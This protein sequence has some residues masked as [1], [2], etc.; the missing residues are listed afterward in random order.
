MRYQ[1]GT[2][3]RQLELEYLERSSAPTGGPTAGSAATVGQQTCAICQTRHVMVESR[4]S[5]RTDLFHTLCFR[6]YH[7]QMQRKRMSTRRRAQAAVR[8]AT[9]DLIDT[10]DTVRQR[11]AMPEPKYLALGHRRRQAQMA[12]RREMDRREAK[13]TDPARACRVARLAALAG[14]AG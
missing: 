4:R 7:L 10:L 14:R 3:A 9:D 6:C 8:A 11:P 2:A 13:T 5:H 1:T 12:A